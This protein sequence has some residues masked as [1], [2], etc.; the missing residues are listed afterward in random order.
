M[1]I[2]NRK[3][4]TAAITALSALHPLHAAAAGTA[5]AD[6]AVSLPENV[7]ILLDAVLSGV[8]DAEQTATLVDAVK[9]AFPDDVP[10]IDAWLA[11]RR[12]DAEQVSS[13]AASAEPASAEP[14]SAP[15]GKRPAAPDASGRK[16]GKGILAIGP[17]DGKIAASGLFSGGNSRNMAGGVS[18]TATRITGP[19]T[20][21]T[22]AYYDIGR[23][24]GVTSQK[25]RGGEYTLDYALSAGT[26]LYGRTSYE[27]DAFSGYDYRVFLG[28]GA[29]HRLYDT[30]KLMLK[31]SGGPGFRYAPVEN[32]TE[33]ESEA[34]VFA[35]GE[36]VW[37]IRKGTTL[38]Q[39]M[40]VTWTAPTTTFF[41]KTGFTNTLA[42]TFATELSVEVD[43][44]TAP[45]AGT[46]NTDVVAK[47][48]LVAG[49]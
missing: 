40:T 23:S 36:A 16:H 33:T 30:E 38:E 29:G 32:S 41:S 12:A 21:K 18:I 49:F 44:E 34:A 3:T 19:F 14:A 10:A 20:H 27:Q 28:A 39:N 24:D 43:Y 45:P 7:V 1:H 11:A 9:A 37:T 25:R 48:S 31:I 8:P 46:E 22:A 15:A 6:S 4:L 47:V 2:V 17:W 5:A 35:S 26:Y 42:G 13:V